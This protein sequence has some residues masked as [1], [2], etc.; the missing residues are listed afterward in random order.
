MVSYYNT[1]TPNTTNKLSFNLNE[2]RPVGMNGQKNVIL[3]RMKVAAVVALMAGIS[4]LIGVVIIFV[5]VQYYGDAFLYVL[6]LVGISVLISLPL[7]VYIIR[8]KRKFQIENKT[9]IV[10]ST[11]GL[12]LSCWEIIAAIIIGMISFSIR[13]G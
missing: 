6:Y 11:I 10:L 4:N 5:A 3:K 13:M 1:N 2:T 12:V 7:F 8:Q 9:P